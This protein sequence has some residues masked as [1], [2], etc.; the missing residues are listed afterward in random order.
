MDNIASAIVESSDRPYF[1]VGVIS[2]IH[3]PKHNADVRSLYEMLQHNRFGLLCRNGDAI[4]GWVWAASE[5]LDLTPMQLCTLDLIVRQQLEDGMRVLDNVGNHDERGALPEVVRAAQ[6]VGLH[7][8]PGLVVMAADQ[9]KTIIMHGH[10]F[11]SNDVNAVISRHADISYGDIDSHDTSSASSAKRLVKRFLAAMGYDCAYRYAAWMH[12][13]D[14]IVIGHRHLPETRD[15]VTFDLRTKFRNMAMRGLVQV[16]PHMIPPLSKLLKIPHVE[17][18]L[19]E[20]FAENSD[21]KFGRMGLKMLDINQTLDLSIM[22]QFR[23][24]KLTPRYRIQIPKDAREGRGPVEFVDAGSW[25]DDNATFLAIHTN[26]QATRV[27]WMEERLKRGLPS[28]MASEQD[29]VAAHYACYGGLHPRTLAQIAFYKD[30]IRGSLPPQESIEAAS[31]PGPQEV[32]SAIIHAGGAVDLKPPAGSKPET[33]AH[34][35]GLAHE[36]RVLEVA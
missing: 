28:D 11:D 30:H 13:A 4:D 19:R 25:I 22:D 21:T 36:A 34:N 24:E 15:L 10:Q 32:W 16:L 29:M 2:D 26:G 17:R 12:D 23:L 14:R 20:I 9:S 33:P 18:S 1:P 31:L 6:D 7:Y 27:N 5:T 35:S 8:G 3:I